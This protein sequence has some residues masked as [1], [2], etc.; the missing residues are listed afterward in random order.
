MKILLTILVRIPLVYSE[1]RTNES[2][3][4][5]SE[6]SPTSLRKINYKFAGLQKSGL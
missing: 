2:K 4:E 6:Y 3:R 1:L 5:L